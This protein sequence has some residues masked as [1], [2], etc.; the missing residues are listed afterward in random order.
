MYCLA[1]GRI[2]TIQDTEEGYVGVESNM[3]KQMIGK[4]GRAH[5]ILRPS[6]KIEIDGEIFDA[7]SEIGY[8][9]KGDPVKVV[10]DE[11]GQLYVIPEKWIVGR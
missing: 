1:T 3:Q 10:R 7:K 11:T 9:E 2:L 4:K 5:T 8:I 6:G